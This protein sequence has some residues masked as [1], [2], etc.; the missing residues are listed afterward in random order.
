MGG[1]ARRHAVLADPDN[2]DAKDLQADAL[3]QLGYPSES[4]P[5]RNFILT[6]AKDLREGV[7]AL[8]TPDA[9]SADSVRAMSPEPFFD[10][11]ESG[12]TAP[13]PAGSS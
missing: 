7:T 13:K 8:P 9:A 4:G 10:S 5:G 2:H 1:R 11:P 6:A 12:S 3:K